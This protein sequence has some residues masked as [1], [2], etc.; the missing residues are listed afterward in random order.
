MNSSASQWISCMTTITR[1]FI[2]TYSTGT[3]SSQPVSMA[4]S[5]PRARKKISASVTTA[6]HT[7]SGPGSPHTSRLTSTTSR[8]P[9]V[10]MAKP[11]SSWVKNRVCRFRGRLWINPTDRPFI[12]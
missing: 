2:P 3:A 5:V 7:S 6:S 9:A 10:S 11:V 1:K 4:H 8:F 12:R